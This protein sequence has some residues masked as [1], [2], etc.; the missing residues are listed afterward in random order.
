LICQSEGWPVP[1]KAEAAPETSAAVAA[2][3]TPMK[4]APARMAL[5]I[6]DFIAILTPLELPCVIGRTKAP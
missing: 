2:S 1:A 6:H 4:P 5:L 3:S